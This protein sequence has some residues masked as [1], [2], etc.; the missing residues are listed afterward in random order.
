MKPDKH[1]RAP[2]CRPPSYR[3]RSQD[4]SGS[5]TCLV[6]TPSAAPILHRPS[7]S[8]GPNGSTRASL[9][10]AARSGQTRPLGIFGPTAFFQIVVS[11]VPP[12]RQVPERAPTQG[13][14]LLG[15]P[16]RVALQA[17]QVGVLSLGMERRGMDIGTGVGNTRGG[18]IR[19]M[20]V[21]TSGPSKVDWAL[22]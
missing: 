7:N 21:H 10:D 19:T 15:A 16:V 14:T 11:L 12:V 22:Y 8:T 6:S 13:A 17:D 1:P 9:S 20:M 18:T 5:M 4:G 3:C 2:R